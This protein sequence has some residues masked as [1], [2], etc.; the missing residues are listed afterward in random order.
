LANSSKS[1]SE[2][3]DNCRDGNTS[4]SRNASSVNLGGI[5]KLTNDPLYA[6]MREFSETI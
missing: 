6:G 5:N 4:A 2:R 3:A 1:Q